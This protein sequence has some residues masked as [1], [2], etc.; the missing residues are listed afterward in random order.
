V[1]ELKDQYP[2]SE[3][4]PWADRLLPGREP[5]DPQLVKL[6]P[7][8]SRG[9]IVERFISSPEFLSHEVRNIGSPHRRYMIELVNKLRFWLLSGD[10]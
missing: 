8:M 1:T 2:T 9:K 3:Y 6:H 7:K 5:E 10:E 4:V